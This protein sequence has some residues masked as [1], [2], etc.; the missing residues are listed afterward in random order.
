MKALASAW[1]RSLFLGQT[2]PEIGPVFVRRST[3]SS[4]PVL[5]LLLPVTLV[6]SGV[7]AIGTRVCHAVR[8]THLSYLDSLE[9]PCLSP[10][11]WRPGAGTIAIYWI[12]LFDEGV[13]ASSVLG[14][15]KRVSEVI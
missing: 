12:L 2:T 9:M 3:A 14:L 10:N 15:R 7:P 4:P 5:P 11:V 13:K 6:A 8:E 1:R